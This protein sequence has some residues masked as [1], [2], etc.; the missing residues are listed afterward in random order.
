MSNES[1]N[2]L[3]LIVAIISLVLIVVGMT[4]LPWV[5]SGDGQ[6]SFTALQIINPQDDAEIDRTILEKTEYAATYD[7]NIT[8]ENGNTQE[9]EAVPL[10]VSVT[11]APYAP[12]TLNLLIVLAVIALICLAVAYLAV[13]ERKDAF[14]SFIVWMGV[15]G[16]YGVLAVLLL[17]ILHPIN[18]SNAQG[19]LRTSL[20]SQVSQQSGGNLVANSIEFSNFQYTEESKPNLGLGFWLVSLGF[21][22]VVAQTFIPREL[23]NTV[24]LESGERS[25]AGSGMIEAYS[26]RAR[27]DLL[28]QFMVSLA[29]VF[30]LLPVIF[31]LSSAF[32]PTGNL[33]TRSLIPS[34]IDHPSEMLT[35]FRALL[36]EETS[37][38]P[39]PTW[40]KNSFIVAT[41]TTVIG[42]MLTALS[43]YSFSR[44]RFAGRRQLLLGILLM[45]V[46]PNLLAMVALFLILQQ[47]T[48]LAEGIPQVLPFLSFIDW[49]WIEVFGLNSLGG[50]ILVY[51]GGVMGINTWLMKGFFDSIPRDI[52][53]SA[54]VD[55]ATHW[56]IFWLLILPLVRPILAVVGIL[57][58]IGT[59]NEFVLARI[60]LKDKE[61]WTLMVGLFTFINN[62]FNKDWGKFAAGALMASV[63]VVIIYIALQDQIVGG[64]TAGSVKG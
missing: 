43:A 2:S 45:Q 19:A 58:F 42:V 24:T 25:E 3:G 21:F 9:R 61:N 8:L 4:A 39:F 30:A 28:S 34:N 22:G 18:F 13:R 40:V 44:F 64:L 11:T 29:I 32:N 49:S 31:I 48:T 59:F 10:R 55:G 62:D 38:W 6:A 20:E 15:A 56:Q 37:L 52:D 53:E 50:V 57:S 51:L 63:P 27:R 23:R 16:V 41:T 5:T 7:A 26:D 33:S 17:M 35:N 60:L 12:E 36:Y 1:N 14:I 46:F 54:L 47:I